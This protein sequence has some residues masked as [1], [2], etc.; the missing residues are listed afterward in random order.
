MTRREMET[1]TDIVI[2]Q[3]FHKPSPVHGQDLHHKEVMGMNVRVG[4][5]TRQFQTGDAFELLP[6]NLDKFCP[7]SVEFVKPLKLGN[8]R[9]A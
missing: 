4:R 9:A 8:P 6:V 3:T 7:S 2:G 5:I 1:I